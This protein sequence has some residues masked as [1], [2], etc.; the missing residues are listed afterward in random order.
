MSNLNLLK[1]TG[2]VAVFFLTAIA[3]LVFSSSLWAQADRGKI[4][5]T[6]TDTTGAVVASVQITA[7]KVATNTKYT[8][9]SNGVGIYS[10]L[11]LPIGAY[12][13]AFKR[14]GF[15]SV[16]QSGIVILANHTAEVN[17]QLRAG[18]E[19]QTVQ[20]TANPILDTQPEVGTNL[21]QDQVNELPLSLTSTGG[22]RD[23]LMYAFSIT[24]NV[25]GDS[26]YSSVNGSQQ[27]TK[28]VL[29]DGT[30]IDSGVVGDLMETGPS[31]DAI[32]QVQVD[33]TGIRAEEAR[34]GGGV[35]MVEMKSG[36]NQ[37]HGSAFAYGSNEDLNAN[38]WDNN[39]FLSQ[40][41]SS[42]A[43]PNGN[44]RSAYARAR[45]RN[46]DY[47]FSGGGPIWK[48]HTFFYT[49]YEK[50]WQDDWRTNPTG[51]S[52]PTA[53]MLNGDF[54][55]LL[56]FAATAR[57]CTSNPCPT[58]YT[59]AAGNPIYYGA[60]FLPNGTV[61]PGNVI[62][63]GM[64]SPIAKKILAIYQQNYKPTGSGIVN[65]F[66]SIISNDPH[67]AQYQYSI[68][69]DHNISA[70]DKFAASYIYNHRPKWEMENPQGMWIPGTRNGGPFTPNS[71]QELHTNAYRFSETHM[72][73]PNILNVASFT[74]NQ[75][76]NLQ[77][78]LAP[79]ADYSS[80][81]GINSQY[82]NKTSDF[83]QISFNGSPNG[84]GE[85]TIG[86]T[87]N[88]GTVPYNGILNES[89][90]W[91][92]G[93]HDLKFGGEI[94][95]LGMNA[96]G[97]QQGASSFNFNQNT[98][99]P[100]QTDA[101]FLNNVAPF[102]GFAFANMELGAVTSGSQGVPISLY[103]RRKEYSL[104]AQDDYKVNRKLTVTLDLRWDLTGAYH[105]LN[106]Q[107]AN[108]DLNAK[109][110]NFGG[111]KGANVWLK[112]RND[113]FET[114]PD[115]HQFGP[116]LGFSY[117]STSKSV[118]RASYGL[119]YS[120][121]GNNIWG[122]V[123]YGYAPGYQGTNNV[124]P[125]GNSSSGQV[126][127]AFLWDSGYPG[128]TVPGSGPMPNQGF[129]NWDSVTIDPH[130]RQLGM[131]ENAFVGFEYQLTSDMKVDVNYNGAFGRNLHDALGTT[132]NWP[133]WDKYQPLL[134]SGHA[135]DWVSD[136]GSAQAAGVP[137]PY[138]GWQ[139]FAYS[140]LTQFPQVANAWSSIYAVGPPIG[141]SGYNAFTVEV[142]KRGKQGLAMDLS[143]NHFRS[144]GNVCDAFQEEWWYGPC[145]LQNPFQY[146]DKKY[147]GSATTGNGVK[148]Y[149]SY[150]LPI[151][152]GHL[153]FGTAN[154]IT[155]AFIG[156][157][158]L[159]T[160]VSYADGGNMGWVGSTN[161]YPGWSG[162]W[163]NVAAH[164]NLKNS[165]KT[166]NPV[167]DPT[168]GAKDTRSLFV[169]PNNFSNPSFGQ[170][171]NSPK[172]FQNW[173]GWAVPNENATITKK[174]HVG[175]S[176]RY[177]ASIRADFFDLLNHHHWNNP[178]MDMGSPYFGH[179]TGVS[180]NR[181]GQLSARFQ[182]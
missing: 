180:G 82:A 137:L 39:W 15:E 152:R 102:V 144:T 119:M 132:Y 20:V 64:I 29:L 76:Q 34:S 181:T 111:L 73:S 70:N 23:Q 164:P 171:G 122:G 156:G 96:S 72:F 114:V 77:S 146:N 101:N 2:R 89:L 138:Q 142:T 16:T 136:Q 33:T 99:E 69:V 58:G 42:S 168:T 9:V 30:S 174:F 81:L 124:N 53:E 88:G 129:V 118:V 105:E 149:A 54:S 43:C 65:N 8:T 83:P 160:I 92:K 28:N 6:V 151:G 182:F 148:G 134:A 106:G 169:D 98:Y 63:S 24:P 175:E 177:T 178:N 97:G 44:P 38:T 71:S 103:G 123:P 150:Q 40:C 12:R 22:G 55:Q 52:A 5:G 109:D 74:F 66:P 139:H 49:A 126:L 125:V 140:A 62:P 86:S 159:G 56:S 158:G 19:S 50:Y 78:T 27:Y 115:G 117:Q 107:W 116:H 18:A 143:Y 14:D 120:P 170:L 45:D 161:N 112:H 179:V 153:L 84:V 108:F 147:W 176:A 51:A 4:T 32:E 110:P 1:R 90:S 91:S 41:G 93:R 79:Q 154:R 100:N 94:R 35:F 80:Q 48:N 3:C 121:V 167:W 85:S 127:P 145:N 172:N 26:W 11:N 157:W 166:W 162:V 59:D 155:D 95:A 21:T 17:V 173:R 61:A 57:G 37:W 128:V 68:K 36:S 10:V 25:G 131:I 75:F 7:T 133:E 47:G 31:N 67:F 104:F 130:S 60:I 113:S 46:Y 135:N 165:F 87:Y 13:I 141:R 163:A